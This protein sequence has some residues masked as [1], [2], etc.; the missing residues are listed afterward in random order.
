[1]RMAMPSG[2]ALLQKKAPLAGAFFVAAIWHLPA[3]A[4]CPLPD[5]PQQVA[6]RQVVDGDT[7]R[8]SDGRSVRLIGINAPELGRKGRASEPYAEAARLRLQA[9]V[10]ASDGRVGLVPGVEKKDKYGRT[11]AHI[12]GRNGDNL[13]AVLLGEGLGYHVAFAPNSRL[14]GCQQAAEHAARIARAGLW[15]RSPVQREGDVRRSGFTVISGR[16]TGLQRNGA[17]VWL[18]LGD[19]VVL[20]VPAR[21]QRNFP[22]SFFDNLRGRQVEARGWM[23]DRSR[24]GGLK[25][26]QRRWML[27]LTDPSM[28][29]GTSG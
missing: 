27:P 25:P 26:G 28:L 22:A 17:G 19:T 9:L 21:L 18:D 10:K 14:A 4:F 24:K 23:L 3:Q 29:Q 16:I 15:Q 13:E 2:F 12:Y 1:M 5:K 20:H 7:V 11:L 6:V 8:L